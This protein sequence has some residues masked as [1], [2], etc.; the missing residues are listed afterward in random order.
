MC[1]GRLKPG[2]T[3]QQAQADMDVVARNLAAAFP[4]AE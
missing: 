4:V 2:V 1:I 3:L